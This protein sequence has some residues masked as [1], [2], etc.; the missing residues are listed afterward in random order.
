MLTLREYL[1]QEPLPLVEIHRAVLDFIRGRGDAVLF[2]A[3]AVNAY[4]AEPRMTQ[5]VDLI[6]TRADGLA[7]E[8]REAL[9][10]RF[11]IAV[12]VR[13]VSHGQGFRI[14]QVVAPKNRHLVDLRQVDVLPPHRSIGEIAVVEPAE[15][16]AGK[17]ISYHQRRAHPK[18]GTDW[19]DIMELLL[20]FPALKTASGP[21]RDRLDAARASES[22]VR[23]WNE[24]VE[25]CIQPDPD[26]Y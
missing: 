13:E 23:T 10:G 11:H 7:Q 22:I 25:T 5:D 26:D 21:V 4:V 1:R 3:Q 19:R 12:R 16:I 18:S 17:V 15:L 6:S 20:A 24:L 8:L 9:S 2:G 14:Y